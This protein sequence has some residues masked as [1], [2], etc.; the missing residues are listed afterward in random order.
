[1]NYAPGE[2]CDFRWRDPNVPY[3]TDPKGTVALRPQEGREI[4]RDSGPLALL[5][6]KDYGSD[7]SQRLRFERPAIISQFAS[8]ALGRHIEQQPVF[9][10]DVYGM[11]TDNMKVFE[12]QRE[13]LSLPAE[14]VLNSRFHILAQDAIEDVGSVAS[15]LRRAIKQAYPRSGKGNK[16]AFDT[17]VADAQR[18][19]WA[20]LRPTY[21]RLL[22]SLANLPP[23]TISEAAR[24]TELNA[25]HEQIR[26]VG[27]RIFNEIIDPLDSDSEALRRQVEARRSFGFALHKLFSPP[28]PPRA[29]KPAASGAP[30]EARNQKPSADGPH[31]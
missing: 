26:Q 5:E 20:T 28:A 15:A 21:G 7:P 3:R 19:L 23:S 14:L 8:L 2:S 16:A 11:R 6:D 30:A 12:W 9:S 24:V 10:L 25:W 4:W 17:L 18:D 22:A 27:V 31:P 13:R 29:K 1:M